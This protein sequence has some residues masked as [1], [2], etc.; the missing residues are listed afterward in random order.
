MAICLH[1][2]CPRCSGSV[3]LDAERRHVS[4][5]GQPDH[6]N[7]A[8]VEGLTDGI[9]AVAMTLLVLDIRLGSTFGRNNIAEGL[10]ALAPRLYSYVISFFVLALFWWA[11]HRLVNLLSHA[12][13][14]FVWWNVVFLFFVTLTPFTVYLL[15]EFYATRIATEC[16]CLNLSVL[17]LLLSVLWKH[18]ESHGLVAPRVE[19][20]QRQTVRLRLLGTLIVYLTTVTIGFW[21]PQWFWLGFAAFVPMRI[22]TKR[23]TR[24][25][26][27]DAA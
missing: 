8:R 24:A 18:G 17:A 9:F 7:L 14:G 26:G 19:A 1:S 5:T 21:F 22:A 13:N 23:I 3:L 20:E 10:F 11:Y 27:D 12:D 15:G 25:V 16:Y 4:T 2:T 6:F